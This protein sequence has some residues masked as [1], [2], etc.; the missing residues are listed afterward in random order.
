MEV[1]LDALRSLEEHKKETATAIERKR[2]EIAIENEKVR[3]LEHVVPH[4]RQFKIYMYVWRGA[5]QAKKFIFIFSSADRSGTAWRL[6][7]PGRQG[8]LRTLGSFSA[9]WS[10]DRRI[11]PPVLRVRRN[12]SPRSETW[13]GEETDKNE[14]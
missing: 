13:Q 14:R 4:Q 10:R 9:P 11:N 7:V 5:A 8:F 1:V 12:S 2:A 6:E 3:D